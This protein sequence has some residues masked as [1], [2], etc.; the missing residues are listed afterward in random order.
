MHWSQL[1]K[2]ILILL[3]SATSHQITRKP[4]AAK[5][6]RLKVK[7]RNKFWNEKNTSK[8]SSDE[9]YFDH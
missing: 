8:L 5:H 1:N 6:G 4:A 3:L 2:N 9:I 7:P